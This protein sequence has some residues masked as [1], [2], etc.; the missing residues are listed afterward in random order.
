MRAAAREKERTAAEKQQQE[1]AADPRYAAMLQHQQMMM[2]QQQRAAA[3]APRAPINFAA[4]N[5]PVRDR[6]AGVITAEEAKEAFQRNEDLGRRF[7]FI[8]VSCLVFLVAVLVFMKYDVETGVEIPLLIADEEGTVMEDT[9]AT[10]RLLEERRLEAERL[11]KEGQVPAATVHTGGVASVSNEEMDR[12][13]ETLGMKAT[14]PTAAATTAG[15]TPSEAAGQHAADAG[16]DADAPTGDATAATED[17]EVKPAAIEPAEGTT[18]PPVVSDAAVGDGAAVVAPPDESK[19]HLT[20]AQQARLDAYKV[21]EAA[22]KAWQ[23]HSTEY[24]SSLVVC[25]KNCQSKHKKMEEAHQALVSQVNVDFYDIMG[26]SQRGGPDG[27]RKIGDRVKQPE[28]G[29]LSATEMETK[30]KEQLTKLE[31]DATLPAKYKEMAV[32][33]LKEAFVTLSDRSL[34]TYYQMYG[35]RPPR[36]MKYTSSTDGGWGQGLMLRTFKNKLVLAWLEY[37]DT[38]WADYSVLIVIGCVGFL[39][40]ALMQLPKII[41]MA[42]EIE[43]RQDEMDELERKA[44]EAG[45]I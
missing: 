34:R 6:N 11:A 17:P 2:L 42:K 39:L 35:R 33:E 13:M 7:R 26:L 23:D 18:E 10:R 22:D 43:R 38:Q 20:P 19:A 3:A 12:Y 30:Y 40:P 1:L 41:E 25:D 24:T 8:F 5:R 21:R 16:K 14:A 28:L 15:A 36:H 27:A 44:R 32:A 37:L 4:T 45:R 9:P 31:G 29:S